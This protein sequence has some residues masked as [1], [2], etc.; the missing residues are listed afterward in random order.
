MQTQVAY[1]ARSQAR[2]G[3]LGLG[4]K[5]A[6]ASGGL[7]LNFA[8]LLISQWLLRLYAPDKERALVAPAF[9]ALAFLAGRVMD[10][11]TD[12]LVG[13]L[14]DRTRSR[15]G[16][17]KPFIAAALLPSAAVSA[18]LWLPPNPAGASWSNAAW[19]FLMVQLFFIA[20][21]LLANPYMSLL[22]ELTLDARERVDLST[23]QALFL[24]LGTVLSAFI[25][26][27]KSAHGWAG[28]AATVF[29]VT[30]VS[31]LPTVFFVRER[32]G[33]PSPTARDEAERPAP[34]VGLPGG[35]PAW[36]VATFANKPFVA[37]LAATSTFWFSLNVMILL[38]P[39][40]VELVGG[41][42][43][44][45]VVLAM[46]PLIGANVA[47]FALCN[48]LAKRFGKR[49]VFLATLGLSGLASIS[50]LAVGRAPLEPFLHTQLV[51]GLYGLATSGFLMLPN[52]LLADVVDFDA[53]RSGMRREAIHFGVQAFFQKVAIGLSIVASSALLFVGGSGAP[54]RMGLDLV[55]GSAGLAALLAAGIFTRYKLR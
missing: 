47:G 11:L 44:A 41:R 42:G 26:S 39:F 15:F 6:Y 29:V 51:M 48:P 22:P 14:S 5:L 32:G 30:M 18:L 43:E 23:L 9:F 45:E 37:L 25:G 46:L 33:S 10:G 4:E 55:A 2:G 20:W 21:T 54:T 52:A 8:N 38:V 53:E 34:P 17:R 1:G 31:F 12:P 27:I 19:L 50:L 49:P 40:W 3:K 7:A 28:L 24:M 35:L 13:Y 16:R 36:I